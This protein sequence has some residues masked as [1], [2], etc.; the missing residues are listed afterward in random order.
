MVIPNASDP[1]EDYQPSFDRAFATPE[2]LAFPLAASFSLDSGST[3]DF[4]VIWNST[5][6]PSSP[7][8]CS[9]LERFLLACRSFLAIFGVGR[10]PR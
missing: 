1:L 2:A 7:R 10:A 5:S 8:S 4:Q 6:S 9:T 3:G